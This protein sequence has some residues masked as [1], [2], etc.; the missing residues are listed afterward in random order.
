MKTHAPV[1]QLVALV[2]EHW[3]QLNHPNAPGLW[4]LYRT[5][6]RLLEVYASII[7]PFGLQ[8]ADSEALCALRSS[9][10]QYTLSPKALG[11]FML[12]SSG[13]LTKVLKRLEGQ[14]WVERLANPEDGRSQL[15]KL[16]PAG[17]VCI[18]AAMGAVSE[19]EKQVSSVLTHDEHA[20]LYSMLDRLTQKI[21]E[22]SQSTP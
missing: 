3:P 1:D 19:F 18:E 2:S 10:A 22:L 20:Q 5:H 9:D 14:G 6:D 11:Y 8:V 12:I 13:G 15:V 16:T 4:S 17:K 7:A 21:D